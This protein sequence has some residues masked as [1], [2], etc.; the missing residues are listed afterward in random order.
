MIDLP[1]KPEV[2]ASDGMAGF[3]TYLIA[4]PENHAITHLVVKSIR[5]PFREML[6]PVE[7]VNATTP[8]RIQLKCSRND[9]DLMEPFE[10]EEYVQS[11]LPGYIYWTDAYGT[12]V[13]PVPGYTTEGVPA[14]IRIKRRNI[15]QGEMAIRRGA[16]VEATDG[17]VG[18]VDELLVDPNTLQVTHLVLSDRHIFQ[19]WEITI[20]VSQIDHVHEDTIFLKLDKQGVDELPATPG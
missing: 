3:V 2:H 11:E 17:Y 6:V 1:K 10:T 16:R 13:P 7:Q 8:D 9:L 15:P 14:L 18:H 5:P 4:N 12:N 19:R 20:P